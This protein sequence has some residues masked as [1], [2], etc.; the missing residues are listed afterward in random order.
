MP[1]LSRRFF[2]LE[3]TP[4]LLV[5]PSVKTEP[6][7]HVPTQHVPTQHVPTR[8][9]LRLDSSGARPSFS[10]RGSRIVSF[11]DKGSAILEFLLLAL[12]LFLPLTLF[13]ANVSHKS[14]IEF[15]ANNLAR[16]LVRAYAT[17]PDASVAP[18]RVA[19]VEQTFEE[20]I[21]KPHGITVP[22]SFS[23]NCSSNPCLSPGSR[24]ELTVSLTSL[25]SASKASAKVIEYVDQWRNS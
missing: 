2:R 18:L 9:V 16:Q 21:L 8:H 11:S 7:Q 14:Q 1:L 24:I 25:S 5:S 22:A 23:I 19:K 20:H 13:L 12:P 10:G 3:T 4:F 17:S 15:D 6:T